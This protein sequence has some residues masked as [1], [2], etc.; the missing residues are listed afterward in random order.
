MMELAQANTNEVCKK[1][2]LGL[3][4]DTPPSLD[5]IIEAYTKRAIIPEPRGKK[6]RNIKNSCCYN[7]STIEQAV[8]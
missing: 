5:L 4:F 7:I 1:I 6:E 8:S 2:I 3:P